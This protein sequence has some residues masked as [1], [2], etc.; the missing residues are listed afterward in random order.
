MN[1]TRS[2]NSTVTTRRSSSIVAPS[3]N[4]HDGQKRDPIAT[5]LAH[6]GHELTTWIVGHQGPH[7][8]DQFEGVKAPSVR[9]DL[10]RKRVIL[11]S[12]GIDEA[13]G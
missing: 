4:P 9:S 5:G 8:V 10:R 1:P 7:A 6:D 2:A 13:V 11:R 3:A 12:D